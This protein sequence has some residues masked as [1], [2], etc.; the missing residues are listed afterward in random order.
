MPPF[1][2][3][4]TDKDRREL[5]RHGFC[6]LGVDEYYEAD[7]TVTLCIECDTCGCVLARCTI[8]KPS[9]D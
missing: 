7:G 6:R 2:I 9:E 8:G 1:T 3:F 5:G 4:L